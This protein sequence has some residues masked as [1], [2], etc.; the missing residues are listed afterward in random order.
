VEPRHINIGFSWNAEWGQPLFGGAPLRR[1]KRG[2]TAFL[3]TVGMFRG[4]TER[5]RLGHRD[6]GRFPE[7]S[8]FAPF[9]QNGILIGSGTK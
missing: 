6:S 5:F 7:K 4:E 9:P 2:G 1:L 8:P 3:D